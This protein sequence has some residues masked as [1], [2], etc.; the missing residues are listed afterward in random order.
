MSLL[1]LLSKSLQLI[2]RSSMSVWSSNKDLITWQG[3]RIFPA[4]AVWWRI[5]FVPNSQEWY[6]NELVRQRSENECGDRKQ[7]RRASHCYHSL[8][9]C[10]IYIYIYLICIMLWGILT[11]INLTDVYVRMSDIPQASDIFV[12]D[13]KVGFVKRET[14]HTKVFIKKFTVTF[15]IFQ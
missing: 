15:F 12:Y 11:V 9:R 4:M 7:P 3:A 5:P 10:T 8:Q 2:W 14:M 1:G 13:E 6:I